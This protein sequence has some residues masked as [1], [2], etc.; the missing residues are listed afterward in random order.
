MEKLCEVA[1]KNGC[2]SFQICRPKDSSNTEYV[3]ISQWKNE[4]EMA[5]FSS[6]PQAI[7]INEENKKADIFLTP[8]TVNEYSV[9]IKS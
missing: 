2:N 7:Q 9:I 6:D 4:Q 8:P 1:K 3:F 5:T